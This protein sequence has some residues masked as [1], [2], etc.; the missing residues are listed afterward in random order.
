MAL[1][2]Q[3]LSGTTKHQSPSDPAFGTEAA[4]TF[5]IGPV[6]VFV[7]TT[8]FDRMLSYQQDDGDK[9]EVSRF[10]LNQ[11]NLDLVRFG[12]KGWSH[13]L[14]ANDNEVPFKTEKR[15]VAGREYV[16]AS[17]ECLVM[18]GVELVRELA[19]KIRHLNTVSVGEAKNSSSAPSP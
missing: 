6:D 4:T 19:G 3:A 10:A 14:D 16:A 11:M 8:I 17:D 12:L 2:I 18:L 1:R 5:L 15:L 13:F 7:S 9:A